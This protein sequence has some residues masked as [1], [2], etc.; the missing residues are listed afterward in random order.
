MDTTAIG[1]L[2]TLI[3]ERGMDSVEEIAERI[4]SCYP[5]RTT[6]DNGIIRSNFDLIGEHTK[7]LP[8]EQ[9]D[10][11]FSAAVAIGAECEKQA[12]LDGLALGAKLA[13]NLLEP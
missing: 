1:L 7:D 10:S 3:R 9:S 4:Y 5:S 13:L 2:S 6:M 12:F 8:F 11:I